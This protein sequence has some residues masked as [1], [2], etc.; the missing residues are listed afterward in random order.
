MFGTTSL[1]GTIDAALREVVDAKRRIELIAMLIE[2]GR[3]D[4]PV[5]D[6]AWGADE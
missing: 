4:L 3:F 5:E 2:E 6:K 1:W